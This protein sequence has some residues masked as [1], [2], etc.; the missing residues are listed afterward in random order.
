MGRGALNTLISIQV[1]YTE[2]I[3]HEIDCDFNASRL[4]LA[5]FVLRGGS[6]DLLIHCLTCFIQHWRPA[7][8]VL[9]MRLTFLLL[10]YMKNEPPSSGFKCKSQSIWCHELH[11]PE[12]H[13]CRISR[14]ILHIHLTHI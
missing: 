13:L 4:D 1:A 9:W 14:S 5:S 7:I 11:H 2:D 12:V 3:G 10:S 6:F 8:F